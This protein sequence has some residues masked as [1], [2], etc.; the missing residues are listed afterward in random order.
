MQ[1]KVRYAVPTVHL[2]FFYLC[3]RKGLD[4]AFVLFS[5]LIML[6]LLPLL[7]LILYID[8]PGPI[9]YKQERVGYRGKK[10]WMYKFRSMAVDA[11]QAGNAVWASESDPRVTR[12]G[13]FLRATH[14]DELPQIINILLG[15]MCLIGPRP[16]REEYVLELEKASPIY[17]N[18]LLV[19][20]GLTGWSQVN[21]GYGSTSKDELTKLQYDLY[22][23]EHQSFKLDIVILLK[24]VG[25][26]VL[27]HGI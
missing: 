19:K 16:E 20:P 10:F 17:R 26:V 22:Y 25:E 9:F 14:L 24:T 7:A 3:W 15:E 1:Q 12:V 21:Y 4:I 5:L 2:P 18:R 11:E 27:C 8:S 13:C 23:I 6:V